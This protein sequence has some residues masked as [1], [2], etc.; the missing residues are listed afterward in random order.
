MHID[1]QLRIEPLVDHP[2]VLPILKEWFETEW[3]SYYG[4]GGPGDAQRDLA[5]YANWSGLPI[6]VVAF[7]ENDL[8]GVAALKAESVTTHSHLGPGRR[9]DWLALCI[10]GEESELN[11][12][13]PLKKSRETSDML[14]FTAAQAQR[15]VSLSAAVGSL[16]SK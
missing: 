3:E 13:V 11:C 16:W 8:C 7:F 4:P 6:G 14:A 9:Q 15:T 5:A 2:E 1:R 10:V 12:S